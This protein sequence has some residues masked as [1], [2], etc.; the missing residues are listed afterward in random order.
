MVEYPLYAT[1]AYNAFVKELVEARLSER[2]DIADMKM[3]SYLI[4]GIEEYTNY[5]IRDLL[6]YADCIGLDISL[7]KCLW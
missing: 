3:P 4:K 5:D 7:E 1:E 6:W 2:I